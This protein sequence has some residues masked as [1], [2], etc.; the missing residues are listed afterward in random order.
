MGEGYTICDPYLFTLAT[1]LEA[2]SIDPKR[3]PRVYDHRNRMAE[4]PATK[5]ALAMEKA[6]AAA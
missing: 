1:W 4:R 5:R 6:A 2:D 3:F